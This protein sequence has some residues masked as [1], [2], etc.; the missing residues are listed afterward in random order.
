MASTQPTQTNVVMGRSES[1]LAFA[2]TCRNLKGSLVTNEAAKRAGVAGT[3]GA[4]F[5]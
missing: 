3:N 2:R 4:D 5:V 1:H